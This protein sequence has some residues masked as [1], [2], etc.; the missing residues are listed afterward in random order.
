MMKIAMSPAAAGLLRSLLA[1]GGHDRDRILLTEFRS[2]D[3]VSLAFTGERHE[4]RLRII[5]EYAGALAARLFDGLEDADIQVGAGHFLA[6]IAVPEGPQKNSDG[7]IS[8]SIEA[9]TVAES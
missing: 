8:V 9:L 6:D 7:S 4:M 2:T 1:R 3:W 5:G